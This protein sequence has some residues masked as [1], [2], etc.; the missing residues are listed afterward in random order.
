VISLDHRIVWLA[1]CSA[2]ARSQVPSNDE[3]L[4]NFANKKLFYLIN[5][6]QYHEVY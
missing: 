3:L 2:K 4:L 5:S 1:L 6:L